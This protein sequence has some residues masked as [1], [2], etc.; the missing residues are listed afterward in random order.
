MNQSILLFFILLKKKFKKD[1]FAV[2]T[3]KINL[4]L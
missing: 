4:K 3:S 1:Y 2:Y